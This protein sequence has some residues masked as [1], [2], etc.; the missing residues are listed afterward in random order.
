MKSSWLKIFGIDEEEARDIVIAFAVIIF[1]VW[2]AYYL[3]WFKSDV[4]QVLPP[5]SKIEHTINDTDNDG[6]ANSSDQCPFVFGIAANAGCPADEDNDGIYDNQD[7]CP[8][9]AGVKENNGCAAVISQPL[10]IPK[11]DIDK[12]GFADDSDHCPSTAGTIHGC[13]SDLDNDGIFDSDDQC[14]DTIGIIENQGCPADADGDGVYDAQDQCKDIA[15]ITTNNGCPSDIDDDGIFDINDRCP[16]QIGTK[17]NQGCPNDSDKDG[18]FDKQDKCPNTIGTK[19]N[20]GCPMDTDGD[21]IDDA[22][23]KCP[24]EAGIA[25]N[26]GCAVIQITQADQSVISEAIKNIRFFSNSARPTEA[27]KILLSKVSNILTKNPSYKLTISGHTDASGNEKANM[28]LSKK[29]AFVC[30]SYLVNSGIASKRLSYVGF[31]QTKPIADNKTR[32]GRRKN[33][34]VEFELHN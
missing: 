21:G 30:F 31:G 4:K 11:P 12:D 7:K 2:L 9:I 16:Q 20:N 1:F 15:G 10:S 17:A 19:L 14:P 3:D 27:S 33:R 28:A 5:P 23:D 18:V 24:Y 13:P 34:R 6:V 26:Q 32:D 25:K 8:N 22:N 29:R